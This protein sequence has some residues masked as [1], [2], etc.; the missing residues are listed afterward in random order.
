[1]NVFT[2][3]NPANLEVPS[4]TQ[5]RQTQTQPLSL[6]QLSTCRWA[7]QN[8]SAF[9]TSSFLMLDGSLERK[10][11]SENRNAIRKIYTGLT[12]ARF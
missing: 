5:I 7:V 8:W 1:M 11:S 10:S 3:E 6:A 12:H 9:A 2:Y 4:L